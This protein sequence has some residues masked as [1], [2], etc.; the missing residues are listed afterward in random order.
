MYTTYT[1]TFLFRFICY[2]FWLW[3][4]LPSRGT[5]DHLVWKP[6]ICS[7]RGVWRTTVWGSATGHLGKSLAI[8]YVRWKYY[9]NL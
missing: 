8:H 2:R 1:L 6:T 7:S 9:S 3:K 5:L 4:L